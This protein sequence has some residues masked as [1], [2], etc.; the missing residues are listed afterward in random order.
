MCFS[1]FFSS[2]YNE[3]IFVR[4]GDKERS[5]QT[6][7]SLLA[8]IRLLLAVGLRALQLPQ[9]LRVHDAQHTHAAPADRQFQRWKMSGGLG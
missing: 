7:R 2:C 8:V 9:P 4:H 3:M 1:V 5:G 6:V